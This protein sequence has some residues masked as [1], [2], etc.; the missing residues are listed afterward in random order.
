[1]SKHTPGP[2]GLRT[3]K[4]DD[5]N[6]LFCR[7]VDDY[8]REV[9]NTATGNFGDENEYA[10]AYL[11][12]ASPEMLYTLENIERALKVDYFQEGPPDRALKYIE[13]IQST[14]RKAKNLP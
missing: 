2:W 13:E 12:A 14:I 8:N 6:M 3:H 11:I 5:G 9:A 10:N 4:D 7:I 1:M